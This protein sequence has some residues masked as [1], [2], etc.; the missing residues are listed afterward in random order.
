[1]KKLAEELLVGPACRGEVQ[2]IHYYMGYSLNSSKRV[3][4]SGFY[5]GQL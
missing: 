5:K 2:A 4:F 3:L 1:M